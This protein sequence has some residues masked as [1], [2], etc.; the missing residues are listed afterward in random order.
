MRLVAAESHGEG[1]LP[2]VRLPS[3]LI[4]KIKGVAE[5]AAPEAKIVW[6]RLFGRLSSPAKSTH[7]LTVPSSRAAAAVPAVDAH[8]AGH[9][10]VLRSHDG[11][12]AAAYVQPVAQSDDAVPAAENA[13]TQS[14]VVVVFVV[15]V[16][17]PVQV[18][19][20]VSVAVPVQLAAAPLSPLTTAASRIC[21]Y[22]A[23]SNATLPYGGCIGIGIIRSG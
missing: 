1:Q 8:P 18:A 15:L 10:P 5:S 11:T 7:A 9:E 12:T 14:G 13:A 2:Q 3:S 16:A 17:T 23:P 21:K 22:V 19:A 20:D 6:K 4:A